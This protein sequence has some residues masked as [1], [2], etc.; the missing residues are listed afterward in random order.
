MALYRA[1]LRWGGAHRGRRL[2]SMAGPLFVKRPYS[3][4]STLICAESRNCGSL[5]ALRAKLA[6]LILVAVVAWSASALHAQQLTEPTAAGLW[7][8]LDQS[9]GPI[10]WFLFVEHDRIY[11]GVIAKIFP[12]P[13]DELHP[14]CSRCVDDRRN[15]PVLGISFIRNMKRRGLRYEDG[16]ILDPRD[17]NV[18][19]AM[20]SVSPDG[21]RLTVRGYLGI[22]LLGMDEVWTRLPE[23][24]VANLDPIVIA[25]Y[26]PG[27]APAGLPASA[28]SQLPNIGTRKPTLPR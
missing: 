1:I 25:K 23:S 20:M 4:G 3:R 21:R 14:V 13:Q 24:A 26:L 10:S 16:N 7:Q 17:G 28:A 6:I 19:H 27:V 12:R 22:P 8:K 5:P 11:E 18:Y 15:A 2:R 9:G